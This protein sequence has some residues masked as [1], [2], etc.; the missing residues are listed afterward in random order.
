MTTNSIIKELS[1]N[2]AGETNSHQAGMLIPK[3]PELLRFFPTLGTESK[4]P[5]CHIDF[6]DASGVKWEFA[7]IYYNNRF[8]GGTRNEYRLTRMTKYIESNGLAAGDEI[9]FSNDNDQKYYVRFRRKNQ[10][11]TDSRDVL[12]LGSGWKKIQ[13]FR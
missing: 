9:E 3:D 4:N 7:F 8:F 12:I 10:I 5:R 1:P 13:L 6:Y 11:N 2:D